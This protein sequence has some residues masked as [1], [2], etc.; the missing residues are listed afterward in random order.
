[1][2]GAVS[3]NLSTGTVDRNIQRVHKYSSDPVVFLAVLILPNVQGNAEL[4][5]NACF[6][7]SAQNNLL[8]FI[9]Y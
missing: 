5:Y 7:I 6:N 4:D 3:S 2:A 8:I 9:Q 1:M